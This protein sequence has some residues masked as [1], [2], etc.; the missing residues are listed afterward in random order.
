MNFEPYARIWEQALSTHSSS[1]RFREIDLMRGIAIVMMV[2]YHLLFDLWFFGIAAVDVLDGFW[3]YFALSTAT[4]FIALAGLSLPI[5]YERRREKMTGLSLWFEYARRGGKIFL[6]G[7][8]ATVATWIFLGEGFIV[9]GILHLI[10]FAI[11][12]AP[13]FL[14]FGRGNFLV[15]A[16]VVL[17]AVP[18][19]RLT[20]PAWLIPLGIHPAGF[21]S[22]DYVPL[23]PWLGVALIGMAIG[24]VLYPGGRRRFRVPAMEGRGV[25]ALCA[26]GRNSLAVYLLH[27]PVIV[28]VLLAVTA[29]TG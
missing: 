11:I 14:R 12:A 4:L 24:F 28:A 8:L 6:F 3:R 2:V 29:A 23:I 18:L 17:A 13:L 20:G 16:G 21:S 15:G 27:Q 7:M 26:M 9:F 5:S 19:G 25:D 1:R 10:G 22:V